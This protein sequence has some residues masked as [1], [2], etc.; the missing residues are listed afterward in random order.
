MKNVKHLT[1]IALLVL[2]INLNLRAQN[3][4]PPPVPQYVVAT[5][6]HWDLTKEDFSMEKWKAGEKEFFDRLSLRRNLCCCTRG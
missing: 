1:A 5:T 6:A 3:D 4:A 2:C